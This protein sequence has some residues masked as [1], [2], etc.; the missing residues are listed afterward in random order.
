PCFNLVGVMDLT[1]RGHMIADIITICA[2]L[3]F[4]IPDIDR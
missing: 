2:A 3:D 4:V 1:T